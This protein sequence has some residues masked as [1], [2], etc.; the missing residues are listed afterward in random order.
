MA[1]QGNQGHRAMRADWQCEATYYFLFGFFQPF[2]IHYS[3]IAMQKNAFLA[4]CAFNSII[5]PLIAVNCL[6]MP[7]LSVL[8]T[9]DHKRQAH[10][11]P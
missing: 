8:S 11:I 1:V 7:F 4:F 10:I 5:M 2:P 6:Q 9:I 3:Q